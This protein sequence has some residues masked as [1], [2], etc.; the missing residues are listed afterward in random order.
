MGVFETL[1]G[2]EGGIPC[3]E[4]I[5]DIS[6]CLDSN[7]RR[8]LEWYPE[9]IGML[10]LA[11]SVVSRERIRKDWRQS[12]LRRQRSS[13]LMMNRMILDIGT[14]QRESVRVSTYT[15]TRR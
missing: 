1:W 14:V 9:V 7:V 8:T 12:Q 11:S 4:E 6:R 2:F 13:F 5:H 10:E 15:P 3:Y